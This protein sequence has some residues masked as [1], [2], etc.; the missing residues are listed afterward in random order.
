MGLFIDCQTH[1]QCG[2]KRPVSFLALI[3]KTTQ[4]TV[5]QFEMYLSVSLINECVSSF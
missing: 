5:I 1:R 2:G 4:K 3:L